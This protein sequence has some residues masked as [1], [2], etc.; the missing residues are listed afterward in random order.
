MTTEV[1]EKAEVLNAFF[2]SVFNSQTNYP[3]GTLSPN[4]EV[5]V[6]EQNETPQLRWKQLETYY[7]TWT[8]TSPRSQMEST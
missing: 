3:R 6:G 4:L 8:V 5:W 2:T 1:K 7:S